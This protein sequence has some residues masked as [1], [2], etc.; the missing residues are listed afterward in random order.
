MIIKN[1]RAETMNKLYL[2]TGPAGVGK[3]T[4]SKEI[5]KS[6][7]KSVLLEGDEFYKHVVGSYVPAWKEGNHLDIFWKVCIDTIKNYLNEG[8][9][10]V[11]NYIIGKNKFYEL[12]QA[13]KD[14]DTKFIVLLVDEATLLKRD[15]E[16]PEDE[17]MKERCSILL[18]SFIN[19]NYEENHILY[20]DNIS[21]SEIINKVIQEDR[22][23][24]SK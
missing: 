22:F 1:E 20:T 19:Y 23:L 7:E 15:A 6:L 14:F 4:V 16:R 2:I 9:D 13:F 18:N 17:Q 12:K 8:Y 21:I 5:A 11:F 3:T 10:V 24:L